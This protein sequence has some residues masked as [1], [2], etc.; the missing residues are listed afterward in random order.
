[1]KLNLII[2]VMKLEIVMNEYNEY[3]ARPV[4]SEKQNS[5]AG[6]EGAD[7]HLHE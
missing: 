1:M 7:K 6:S 2:Y 5:A 3:I 4:S